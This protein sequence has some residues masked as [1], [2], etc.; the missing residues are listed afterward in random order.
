MRN[1]LGDAPEPVALDCQD[2]LWPE[3]VSDLGDQAVPTLAALRDRA[4]VFLRV[5]GTRTTIEEVS[6]ALL[7]DDIETEPHPLSRTALVVASNER[8]LR[9]SPAYL[10]GLVELQD[11]ASQAV[12]DTCLSHVRGERVL[13]YCAGGGGKSLAFAGAG[14]AHVT[15]HDADPGRMKDIPAR[16]SRAGTPVEVAERVDGTFDFVLCD[17]PCSGS[18][19]WRRQPEAKWTLDE[20]RLALLNRTQDAILDKAVAHVAREGHLAY[21]T[22]SILSRENEQRAD[23]FL[24]RHPGWSCVEQ[25]RWSLLEGADGFFLAIFQRS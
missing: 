8:R 15:A 17:A 5:N 25:R 9:N 7:E 3:I 22:C 20:E 19:A 12:V 6:R 1:S 24:A 14:L 21:A 11:A 16:A 18:G 23:T 2:W 10:E 4:P 13:D